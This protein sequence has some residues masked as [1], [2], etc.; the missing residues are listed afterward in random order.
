ME[1]ASEP[2]DRSEAWIAD[3]SFEARDLC[4]VETAG[5]GESFLGQP[6]SFPRLAKVFSELLSRLHPAG[7]CGY[8]ANWP[9]AKTS[10]TVKPCSHDSFSRPLEWQQH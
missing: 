5:I 7:S 1:G 2:N 4:E 9:R 6:G 8:K 10:S 3:S